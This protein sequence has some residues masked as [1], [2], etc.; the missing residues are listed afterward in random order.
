M[1]FNTTLETEALQVC[2]YPMALNHLKVQ[3]LSLCPCLPCL[4]PRSILPSLCPTYISLLP[5]LFSK[6]DTHTSTP[7][8][9]TQAHLHHTHTH[10]LTSYLF[11][12]FVLPWKPTPIAQL[13]SFFFIPVTSAKA[14][15]IA[16]SNFS[17]TL[18]RITILLFVPLIGVHCHSPR[19]AEEESRT[20]LQQGL[21]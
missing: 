19:Y 2:Q 8:L 20:H 9:H 6:L 17:H 14:A 13:P 15:C 16:A 21:T 3:G 10:T 5:P 7:A 4:L 12:T 18:S 11:W 1:R